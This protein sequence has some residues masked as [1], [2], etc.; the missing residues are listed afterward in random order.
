[1]I[2]KMQ[3]SN[4]ENI[5]ISQQEYDKF[6]D[7]I[8]ANFVELNNRI[9]NPSFVV[10]VTPDYEATSQENGKIANEELKERLNAPMEFELDDVKKLR[11]SLNN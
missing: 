6:K 7:N 9:V 11:E 5:S 1:M 8:S 4:K 10:S 2:Y 3:L